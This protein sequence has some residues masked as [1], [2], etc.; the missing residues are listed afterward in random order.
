MLKSN[1]YSTICYLMNNKIQCF[2]L[3]IFENNCIVIETNLKNFYEKIIE[4]DVGL[5]MSLSTLRKRFLE[6]T[7]FSILIQHNRIY[8]FQKIENETRNKIH[9]ITS[10]VNNA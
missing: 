1:I 2:F 8:H 5:K 10:K 3:L 4:R 6:N 9:V 7:S